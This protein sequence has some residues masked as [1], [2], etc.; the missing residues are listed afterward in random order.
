MNKNV[1]KQFQLLPYAAVAAKRNGFLS[2]LIRT[3]AE[4]YISRPSI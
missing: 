2:C 3:M 1:E 4:K